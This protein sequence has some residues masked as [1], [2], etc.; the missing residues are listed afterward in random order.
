[1]NTN[2]NP[3]WAAGDRSN[4]PTNIGLSCSDVKLRL[5]RRWHETLQLFG[6]DSQ[7]LTGRHCPCPVN[8]CGGKDRFR[9]DNKGGDGTFFCNNCGA[10]DGI[11]LLT[12]C[13]GKPVGEV[14]HLLT[15]YLSGT[16]PQ[17]LWYP[18]GSV[19]IDRRLTDIENSNRR[20]RDRVQRIWRGTEK[21]D[22]PTLDPVHAYLT[23][24]RKLALSNI[25]DVLRLAK[26]LEYWDG[27]RVLDKFPAMVAP[28]TNIAGEMV[29][30]HCTYLTK[31][32]QKASVPSP[33]KLMP[34]STRGATMG[35]AIK[36]F[37]AG[38]VL[39]VAEGIE[40]AL[41]CYLSTNIETW[42]TVSANGMA[43][44]QIPEIVEEVIIFADN[45]LSGTGQRAA[46]ALAERLL[47]EGKQTKVLVPPKPG[48]DWAD[49]YIARQGGS[50]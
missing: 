10:G 33:K 3:S 29:T 44:L 34:P 35:A 30:V 24:T 38:R 48:T 1:M 47:S 12:L 28:V 43:R 2:T 5:K 13:L 20:N 26:W 45:D 42:A 9:F 19:V 32:G 25:P 37:P 21:L 15:D 31:N 50:H 39:G 14:L 16:T 49:I 40:T 23:V 27:A 7:Y 6:I 36:L 18:P 41:A 46:Y 17:T 4:S 8:G 22:V 11:K